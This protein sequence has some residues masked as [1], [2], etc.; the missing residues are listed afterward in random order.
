MKRYIL[1]ICSM[2]IIIKAHTQVTMQWDYFMNSSFRN[3]NKVI[4]GE[5]DFQRL[6]ARV[7][8]PFSSKLD[9]FGKPRVWNAT[10]T[11]THGWLGNKGLAYELNP[12]QILNANISVSHIRNLNENWMLIASLGVGI[13]APTNNVSFKSVLANGGAIFAYQLTDNF[14]VGLGAGLTNSYGAPMIMPMGYL[15]WQSSGRVEVQLNIS[16]V[17]KANVKIKA[18]KK[19]TFDITPIEF[20]GMS[21]VIKYDGKDRLYSMFMIR[22]LLTCDMNLW[23]GFSVFGGAGG[24]LLRNTSIQER[25]I[26]NLFSGD[27]ANKYRF[28]TTPQFSAGIR[29]KF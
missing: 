29:Y 19:M 17:V 21:A 23:K 24:V 11:V 15:N 16:N 4:C 25:K 8:I 26:G 10:M 9:N 14:S 13:Y 3:N 22:S 27:D 12:S 18:T 28:N 5:G 20:D 1:L 7:N 6:K 2:F